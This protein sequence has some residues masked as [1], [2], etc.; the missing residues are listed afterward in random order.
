VQSARNVLLC[1]YELPRGSLL[2]NPYAAGRILM[3]QDRGYAPSI[4]PAAES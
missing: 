2:G 1:I 3:P 4:H